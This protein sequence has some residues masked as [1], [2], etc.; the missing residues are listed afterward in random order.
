M[1]LQ[2]SRLGSQAAIV[3]IF[4]TPLV[5]QCRAGLWIQCSEVQC[6]S[7]SIWRNMFVRYPLVNIQKTIEAMAIEIVDLPS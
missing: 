1:A 6:G 2:S 4:S 3:G 7:R 5:M